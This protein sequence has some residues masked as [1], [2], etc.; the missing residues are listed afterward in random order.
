MPRLTKS[1]IKKANP[2]LTPDDVAAT[3]SA[4]ADRHQA[5]MAGGWYQDHEAEK[6]KP[7]NDG[8]FH[9]SSR[10]AKAS[11]QPQPSRGGLL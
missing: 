10:A 11:R 9:S 8:A 4:A 7:R 2:T 5:L 1:Q 6:E 3:A